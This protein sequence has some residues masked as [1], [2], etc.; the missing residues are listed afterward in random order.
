MNYLFSEP[1]NCFHCPLHQ[2]AIRI[3]LVEEMDFHQVVL[4]FH[5]L[6][7]VILLLVDI[8]DSN[9]STLLSSTYLGGSDNDGLNTS[10]KLKRKC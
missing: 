1:G 10:Q 4:E 2:D 8:S 9:G 6:M 3:L 7:V 5:F